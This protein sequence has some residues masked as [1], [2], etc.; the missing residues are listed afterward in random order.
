MKAAQT[1][2]RQEPDDPERH[3]S[4]QSGEHAPEETREPRPTPQAATGELM[5]RNEPLPP[6]AIRHPACGKWWT[7]LSRAHCP[8]CC[9]TFS[10]DSAANKHRV[11]KFGVDRRC[12]DPAEAGLVA[13]EKP[14]GVL[15][16]FPAPEG[17]YTAARLGLRDGSDFTVNGEVI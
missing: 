9:E 17:G 7:G 6:N 11:G 16:S 2:H 3:S 1:G 15:W 5:Q 8:A 12:V 10:T 13:N 4:P 14:Y